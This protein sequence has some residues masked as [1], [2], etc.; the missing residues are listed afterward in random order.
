M[1]IAL[2]DAKCTTAAPGMWYKALH[3][4]LPT[5]TPRRAKAQ[6]HHLQLLVI[7]VEISLPHHLQAPQTRTSRPLTHALTN[8]PVGSD[9]VLCPSVGAASKMALLSPT[10]CYSYPIAH[11]EWSVCPTACDR[12]ASTW[13]LGLGDN[14]LGL[15][16]WMPALTLSDHWP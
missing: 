5:E 7:C 3:D 1:Q 15:P 4:S 11:W 2:Y 10:S 12:R 9:P 16:S 13:V 14:Q 6:E 8:C